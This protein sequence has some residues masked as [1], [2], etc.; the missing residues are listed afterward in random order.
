MDENEGLRAR[1]RDM[2]SAATDRTGLLRPAA[3]LLHPVTTARELPW[4]STELVK[5]ALGRSDITIDPKDR[6]FGD[7]AWQSNAVYNRIGR[8]Y[9]LFEQLMGRLV[10]VAPGGWERKARARYLANI[11]TG[12]ASP[13]NFLPTNPTAIKRAFDTGGL[14]LAR[15]VR[16][17]AGDLTRGGM[18]SMADRRP[19]PVG[20]KLAVSPGAVVYRDEM[21][22][23]LQYAPATPAVRSRPLLMVPPQLN[24]YYVLDLA[25]GRSMIEFI[26]GQG[27][28]PFM[29]VWRNPRAELGH[30]KWGLDEYFAAVSRALDVTRQVTGSEDVNMLGL[31]AGGLTAALFLGYLAAQGDTS[32]HALTLMVTLLAGNYPNVLGQ[33]DTPGSRQMLRRSASL[34][35]VLPGHMLRTTFAWLRPDDL[36]FNYLVSGWLLGDQPHA[37]DVLAWNDDATG[38]TAK[39][40]LECSELVVENRASRPGAVSVLGTPIDLDKVGC[41]SFHVA[42]YTDHISPWRAAYATA[43]LLGGSKEMVVVKSGHIQSFVNP[44]KNSRYDYWDGPPSAADPEEWLATATFQHGSWWPRWGEWIVARS[45]DEK[46][47]PDTLGSTKHPPLDPAPGSYVFG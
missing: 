21:I 42:G 7:V 39:L 25:P 47:A 1:A 36:V 11:I 23:L 6:K 33:F 14:S 19:F 12:A 17:M 41:D 24:R 43:Q 4:F 5:I 9:K 40:G 22:E 18:P 27:I 16:N 34:G 8:S 30:G 31:C 20:E 38:V 37:F 10:D 13:T 15:G 35:Q 3:D 46:P 28:Q 45:G 32:V 2:V 29:I 44:V 26:V